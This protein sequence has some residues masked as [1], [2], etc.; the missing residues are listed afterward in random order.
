MSHLFIGSMGG[1]SG[2]NQGCV[3]RESRNRLVAEQSMDPE[4][5]PLFKLVLT[6]ERMQKVS[7]G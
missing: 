4:L 5:S 1:E 6:E 3:R 2:D 7:R